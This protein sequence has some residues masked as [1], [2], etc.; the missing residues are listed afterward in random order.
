MSTVLQRHLLHVTGLPW[1]RGRS[2][3]LEKAVKKP[4]ATV[5]KH[6]ALQARATTHDTPFKQPPNAPED[7]RNCNANL[8]LREGDQRERRLQLRLLHVTG[9]S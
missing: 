9:F 1:P 3:A 5:V 6:E 2:W 7:A 8:R 4:E